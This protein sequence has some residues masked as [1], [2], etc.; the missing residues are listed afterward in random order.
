MPITR[1]DLKRFLGLTNYYYKIVPKIAKI[2][3]SIKKILGGP[4]KTNRIILQL[5]EAQV[6]SFKK[7]KVH[8]RSQ[9]L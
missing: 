7:K 2:T 9:Q 1:R 8:K 5:N 3:A 4:K 6:Q